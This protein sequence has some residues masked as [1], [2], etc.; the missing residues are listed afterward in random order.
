MNRY[1]FIHTPR[2]Y[3]LVILLAILPVILLWFTSACKK[4]PENAKVV[5]V[6]NL[7]DEVNDLRM[8]LSADRMNELFTSI[9]ALEEY[10]E[11]IEQG[12]FDTIHDLRMAVI[13]PAYRQAYEV[14]VECKEGCIDL[15][16]EISYLEN[17]LLIFIDEIKK[18]LVSENDFSL[19]F[20][21][22]AELVRDMR[23]RLKNSL[24]VVEFH[25]GNFSKYLPVMEPYRK[26]ILA[27]MQ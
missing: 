12:S 4:K 22:E 10:H 23:E 27:A 3:R 5:I 24:K 19:R 13:L 18:D 9:T 8:I 2:S 7:L 25:M 17:S 21:Q 6:E 16:K 11:L 20:S 1:R 14:L 15:Q 26:T